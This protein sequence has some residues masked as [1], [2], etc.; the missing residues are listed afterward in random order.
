MQRSTGYHTAVCLPELKRPRKQAPRAKRIFVFF[1]FRSQKHKTGNKHCCVFSRGGKRKQA[2]RR[3]A[4]KRKYAAFIFLL[5]PEPK[6][7]AWVLSVLSDETY[8][9]FGRASV[10][11][12]Q[13]TPCSDSSNPKKHPLCTKK[14][15]Y[16]CDLH[17]RRLNKHRFPISFRTRVSQFSLQDALAMHWSRQHMS[18][19][20]T[21]VHTFMR[22]GGGGAHHANKHSRLLLIQMTMEEIGIQVCAGVF[23]SPSSQYCLARRK[24][25]ASRG[26]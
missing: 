6:L 13:L 17:N 5:R 16:F 3:R 14:L 21:E 15:A 18:T 19:T 4:M 1:F 23:F 20:T 12:H 7:R 9:A 22:G 11:S 8:P 10:F 24:S 25:C 26:A 2:P